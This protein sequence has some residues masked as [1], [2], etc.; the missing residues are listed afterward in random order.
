MSAAP[1]LALLAVLGAAGI[2]HAQPIAYVDEVL[3]MGGP[4][5]EV[6][7]ELVN[8]VIR[9][10]GLEPRHALLEQRKPCGDEP[11][12][13]SERA[14]KHGASIAIRFVVVEVGGKIVIS[15]LASSGDRVRRERVEE[16]DLTSPPSLLVAVLAELA[17]R[18]ARRSRNVGAWTLAASSA[19]LGIAGA[20]AT[21]YAHDLRNEFYD[22]Y[23]TPEGDVL[24]ISPTDARAEERRARRW[25]MLGGVAFGAAA[26]SGVAA[27]VLF[28]R[29]SAGDEPRPAGVALLV[30]WP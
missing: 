12:C 15:M 28:V 8:A 21:W 10:A 24:G 26:V 16:T 7:L 6:A 19:A 29:T 14:H 11:R 20:I 1:L 5:P 9:R 3:V 22:A 4:E 18:P 23:V 2:V 17:P 27:T 13:L 30:R 25:S